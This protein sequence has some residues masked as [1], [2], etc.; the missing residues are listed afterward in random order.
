[1]SFEMDREH[2]ESV[3]SVLD[4][5]SRY[6]FDWPMPGMAI[7]VPFRIF[8]SLIVADLW[9]DNGPSVL[10]SFDLGIY[11]Q[12][13]RLVSTGPIEQRGPMSRQFT[14]LIPGTTCL[15]GGDFYWALSFDN[16]QAPVMGILPRPSLPP[17]TLGVSMQLGAFPLPAIATLALP[18]SQ[19]IPSCGHRQASP[20][21]PR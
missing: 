10:G 20:P 13:T 17:Q 7:F 6:W 19:F 18:T 2:E 21:A 8:D 16:A 4:P 1:M 3:G 9:V 15:A 14:D 5:L 11:W 12:G